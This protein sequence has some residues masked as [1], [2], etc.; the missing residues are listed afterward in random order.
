MTSH[1]D[2]IWRGMK[3]VLRSKTWL[4]WKFCIFVLFYSVKTLP[5]KNVLGLFV[6]ATKA[7]HLLAV[8]VHFL[9]KEILFMLLTLIAHVI[10]IPTGS[11]WAIHHKNSPKSNSLQKINHHWFLCT[12]LIN[13]MMQSNNIRLG[14]AGWGGRWLFLR[15]TAYRSI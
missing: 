14:W 12:K 2:F 13:W 11:M 4:Y 10:S 9:T 1:K 3:Q 6:A 15:L 5:F 8:Q 7:L